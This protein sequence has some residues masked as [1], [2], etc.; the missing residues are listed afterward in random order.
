[1]IINSIVD[2]AAPTAFYTSVGNTAITVIYFC[3]TSGSTRVLDVYLFP[4][5]GA[6]AANTQIYKSVSIPA[7]ETFVIDMEKIIFANGDELAAKVDGG[8][9]LTVTVSYVGV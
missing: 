3:N 6:G 2:N 5:G 9:D 8:T 7:G 1:M 4:T